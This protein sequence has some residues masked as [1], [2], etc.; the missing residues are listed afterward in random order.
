MWDRLLSQLGD[1][2][3]QG[4]TPCFLMVGRSSSPLSLARG[5]ARVYSG[6]S[7]CGIRFNDICSNMMRS[8]SET[9]VQNELKNSVPKDYC[10][11]VEANGLVEHGLTRSDCI[12]LV[13]L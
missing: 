13:D 4:A 1:D 3:T 11:D 7:E 5:V 2:I 9:G 10:S 6:L 12:Y 8:D